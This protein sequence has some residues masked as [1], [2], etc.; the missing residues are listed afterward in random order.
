M[1]LL[2]FIF[3]HIVNLHTPIR[4]CLFLDGWT[5]GHTNYKLKKV[6]YDLIE[7][8]AMY[9]FCSKTNFFFIMFTQHIYITSNKYQTWKVRHQWQS[10]DI[11]C[12]QIQTPNR[13]KNT[14]FTCSS[15]WTA[16]WEALNWIFAHKSRT[17]SLLKL[18]EISQIR[19]TRVGPS[20]YI[21]YPT[22]VISR[23]LCSLNPIIWSLDL[24][25]KSKRGANTLCCPSLWKGFHARTLSNLISRNWRLSTT[26]INSAIRF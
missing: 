20:A 15:R 1:K 3:I 2:F 24:L 14:C 4:L 9:V 22:F 13:S 10:T 26:E 25:S 7:Q 19:K 16:N 17:V 6:Q 21:S 5:Q 8:D 12:W 11:R 18:S 23:P